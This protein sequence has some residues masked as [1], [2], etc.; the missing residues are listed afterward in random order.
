MME[1]KKNKRKG[2]GWRTRKR[3]GFSVKW[4]GKRA[5]EGGQ[6]TEERQL[7]KNTP[8]PPSS[9]VKF[10]LCV[11]VRE[12][13]SALTLWGLS[14]TKL[15][16]DGEMLH[17]CSCPSSDSEAILELPTK[18]THPPTDDLSVRVSGLFFNRIPSLFFTVISGLL[19]KKN[20]Y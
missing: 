9:L 1:E 3:D 19:E 7:L 13:V 10:D 14:Q 4:A 5:D 12:R 17:G 18:V 2:E 6:G 8:P 16:K 15:L 20:L 11:F